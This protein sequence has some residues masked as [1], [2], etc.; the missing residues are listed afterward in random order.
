[1]ARHLPAY[2]NPAVRLTAAIACGGEPGPAC[3]RGASAAR[4]E[5]RGRAVA[6]PEAAIARAET[7]NAE[8]AQAPKPRKK[9]VAETRT[10]RALVETYYRSADFRH[11]A[12]QTQYDYRLKLGIWLWLF[13]DTLVRA[14]RK[15]HM[16][17][18]G[19]ACTT[20]AAITRPPA[21]PAS[22]AP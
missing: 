11:L 16:V 19:S 7:P 20:R 10:C 8:I 1:M 15:P 17:A 12:P 6:R 13:G 22:S 14:V 2:S 4:T 5:G 18:S 9:L 21:S 3:A